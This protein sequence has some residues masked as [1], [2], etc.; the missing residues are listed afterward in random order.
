MT[1]QSKIGDN[2]RLVLINATDRESTLPSP[3]VQVNCAD[4][5]SIEFA[6]AIDVHRL[7]RAKEK[8]ALTQRVDR[9]KRARVA[10]TAPSRDIVV[11]DGVTSNRQSSSN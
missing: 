8:R 6:R 3:R 11:V 7:V 5:I 1:V 10:P 4:V 9:S 2:F